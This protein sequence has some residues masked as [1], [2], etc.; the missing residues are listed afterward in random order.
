[1]IFLG[2]L[3]QMFLTAILFTQRFQVFPPAPLFMRCTSLG[4]RWR[5]SLHAALYN[6]PSPSASVVPASL[7]PHAFSHFPFPSLHFC[8]P[9]L[10]FFSPPGAPPSFRHGRHLTCTE[11]Q[12]HK[13]NQAEIHPAQLPA[14][15]PSQKMHHTVTVPWKDFQA[16]KG[17]A[18]DVKSLSMARCSLLPD[19]CLW[20]AEGWVGIKVSVEG[21]KRRVLS[22]RGRPKREKE[23]S[24]FS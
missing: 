14:S 9:S 8:C 11:V 16:Q 21:G 17:R 10:R 2:M 3:L 6:S 5:V 13:L 20:V 19:I 7:G 22:R 23:Q 24:W 4:L 15:K 18:P 1:M 12:R